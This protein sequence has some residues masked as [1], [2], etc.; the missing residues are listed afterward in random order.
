MPLLLQVKADLDKRG[1]RVIEEQHEHRHQ[2]K[3][4]VQRQP[5]PASPSVADTVA[6]FLHLASGAAKFAME[7]S[8]PSTCMI[9]SLSLLL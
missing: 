3:V 7:A 8:C 4:E 2:T 6:G 9:I 1:G 5:Q